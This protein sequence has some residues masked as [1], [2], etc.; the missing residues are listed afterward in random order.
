M[1]IIV[2]NVM[3]TAAAELLISRGVCGV[4][5]L[6]DDNRVLGVVSEADLLAKKE[7]KERYYGDDYRPPRRARIR[8]SAGSEG[9]GYRKSE[10]EEPVKRS[11]AVSHTRAGCGYR[12]P[13][14]TGRACRN[15]RVRVGAGG[16]GA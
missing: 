1:T 8:H 3:T 16:P 15:V 5:V 11:Q 14:W 4:P 6:D 10:G 13:R 2:A 12:S 9:S 7:F